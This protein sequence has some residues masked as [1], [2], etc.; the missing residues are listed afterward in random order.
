MHPPAPNLDDGD[1]PPMVT[2]NVC[3]RVDC[4]GC[5]ALPESKRLAPPIAWEAA[6]RLPDRLWVTALS[7]STEPARTFGTLQDGRI[8]PAI[9]FA[10]LAET[11]AIGSLAALVILGGLFAA[12]QLSWRVLKSP[13][14]LA[15]VA[16]IVEALAVLMVALHALWGL[17]IELGALAPSKSHLRQGLRFGLYACG[18]DLITSPAGVLQGLSRRGLVRAWGP[19][20]AAV[21]V[22][23][24]ALR[25]Y[26]QDCRRLEPAE[27]RRGNRLSVVVLGSALLLLLCAL[28]GIGVHY[29]E[30]LFAQTFA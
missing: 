20:V 11:L 10:L 25:A 13:L 2:C 22:P 26:V 12:P 16:G 3:G 28:L 30:W 6:G 17:C 19:I 7:S 23:R 27:Q 9:G 21:R 29:A 18:W 1:V 5:D 4:A 14:G 24:L 8:G 15:G